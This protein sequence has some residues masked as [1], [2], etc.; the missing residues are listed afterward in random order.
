[1]LVRRIGIRLRGA[2]RRHAPRLLTDDAERFAAGRERACS[3]AR[4]QQLLGPAGAGLDEVLAVVEHDQQLAMAH[5]V[6]QRVEQRTARLLVHIEHAGHHARHKHRVG[7]RRQLDEPHAVLVCGLHRVGHLE[8]KTCLA[9]AAGAGQRQQVRVGQQLDH[10]RELGLASDQRGQVQR[11]VVRNARAFDCCRC[12]L[13]RRAR[14]VG[15]QRQREAVAAPGH[16][17]DRLGAEQLAQRRDLLAQ[18]VFLD[19]ETGPDEREQLVAADHAVA[20]LDQRD[21]HVEGARAQRCVCAGYQQPAL[22]EPH[23]EAVEAI[24]ENGG[25]HRS[26]TTFTRASST[27]RRGRTTLNPVETIPDR[28]VVRGG[29][30]APAEPHGSEHPHTAHS[31]KI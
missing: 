24:G 19:H 9:D 6:E 30:P 7:D 8:R 27:L 12:L 11:Q 14:I 13:L 22:R 10:R 5:E 3:C 31:G 28:Q 29:T 26:F 21:Q 2:Q 23:F 15:V 1:M 18:V 4:V 25:R 20:P 17:D 16:R